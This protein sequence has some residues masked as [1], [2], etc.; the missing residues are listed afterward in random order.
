MN[1][2]NKRRGIAGTIREAREGRYTL[3][4]ICSIETNSSTTTHSVKQ[5]ATRWANV[6]PRQWTFDIGFGW[7]VKVGSIQAT[8]CAT[9]KGVEVANWVS[10]RFLTGRSRE[11][12]I[13]QASSKVSLECRI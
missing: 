3:W 6:S 11:S 4:N 13:A 9:C 8:V 10:V 2:A 12:V 7:N 5:L 1:V